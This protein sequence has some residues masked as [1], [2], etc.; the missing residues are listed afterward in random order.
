[1]VRARMVCGGFV[2]GCVWPRRARSCL[3]KALDACRWPPSAG[4]EASA[5]KAGADGQ[6]WHQFSADGALDE[7]KVAAQSQYRGGEDGSTQCGWQ[8]GS[9]RTRGG[10][11]GRVRGPLACSR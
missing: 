1:M 3:I 5:L 9:R 2:S 7:A 11:C 6:E 4:I 8:V 10:T